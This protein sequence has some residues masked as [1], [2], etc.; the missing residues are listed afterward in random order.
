MIAREKRYEESSKEETRQRFEEEDVGFR[1]TPAHSRQKTRLDDFFL[2]GL[3]IPISYGLHTR[4]HTYIYILERS[5]RDRP[6][7]L[8]NR[9]WKLRSYKESDT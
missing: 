8:L 5:T 9:T 6:G 3:R 4:I 7:V 2:S 1:P